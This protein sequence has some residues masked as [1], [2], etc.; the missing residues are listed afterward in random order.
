MLSVLLI[1]TVMHKLLLA[2]VLYSQYSTTGVT[3][4]CNC[5][6]KRYLAANQ[7]SS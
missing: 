2:S 7:S 1:L 3:I 4:L 6:C 5:T